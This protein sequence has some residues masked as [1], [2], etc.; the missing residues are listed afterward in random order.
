MIVEMGMIR[1]IDESLESIFSWSSIFPDHLEQI[2]MLQ[3]DG[4]TDQRTD[5]RTDRGPWRASSWFSLGP[6]HL[7][8]SS[9]VYFRC[10]GRMHY[11]PTD[12][13]TDRPTDR[14]NGLTDK[15]SYRKYT[16]RRKT[17][18]ISLCPVRFFLYETTP[19]GAERSDFRY[20]Q[21]EG[22]P[23]SSARVQ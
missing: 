7:S 20:H 16:H 2:Q 13:P 1:G 10:S 5:G 18:A 12:G 22:S 3:T 8:R 21:K 11:R 9:R 15:A 14:K 23:L 4:P 19:F 6:L 17:M